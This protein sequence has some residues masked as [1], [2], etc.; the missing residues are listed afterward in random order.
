MLWLLGNSNHKQE[1]VIIDICMTII[2]KICCKA[3]FKME[4]YKENDGI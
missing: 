1:I 3:L 4:K 2:F